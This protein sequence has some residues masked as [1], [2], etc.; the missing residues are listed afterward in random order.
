MQK[1]LILTIKAYQYL[2]SPFLGSNCRYL[3]SCSQYTE[4]AIM[5]HGVRK[6]IFL[7]AARICRCH[8]LKEGGYDP[9][10]DL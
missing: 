10:P 8:P 2:I 4:E 7:G 6:G 1:L 9:V 3:P 5:K